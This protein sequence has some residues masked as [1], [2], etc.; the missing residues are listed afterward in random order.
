MSDTRKA[1]LLRSSVVR[2]VGLWEEVMA[3]AH[4][5]L[6]QYLNGNDDVELPLADCHLVFTRLHRA[7][8]A[9]TLHTQ[10]R[11]AP[12]SCGGKLYVPDLEGREWVKMI[13]LSDVVP[14]DDELS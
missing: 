3:E 10:G 13:D 6:D 2:T 4:E 9:F 8:S 14:I 1:D 11:V 5:V 12:V 7:V